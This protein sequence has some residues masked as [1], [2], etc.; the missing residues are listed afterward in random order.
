[1]DDAELVFAQ[2]WMKEAL[3]EATKAIS[4]GEVPVGAVFVEHKVC[5]G[6]RHLEH[7]SIVA[8][9]HNLTNCTRNVRLHLCSSLF[10]A[11]FAIES[12]T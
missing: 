4:E 6:V 10:M 2:K 7:G 1:M 3:A 5:D 8:R 12:I 9:G 11:K